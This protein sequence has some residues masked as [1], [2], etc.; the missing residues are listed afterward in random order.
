MAKQEY[1]A[2]KVVED[3]KALQLDG[4]VVSLDLTEDAWEYGAPPPGEAVYTGKL[5]LDKDGILQGLEN[6]K[7]PKTVYFQFN[8]IVKIVEGDYEGV[9]VY[10]R[11]STRIYRGKNISTMAGLIVKLGFKI[12]DKL[13]PKQQA[14][15]M[16]AALKKEPV[17][18]FEI[19]WRG[20]YVYKNPKGD[21]E[22]ENVFRH[23]K[24]FPEDKENPGTRLHV[25]SVT[26]KHNGGMAEVRAQTQIARFY[27]MKEE[28]KAIKAQTV[29]GV[30]KIA[31][32]PEL[33][34][35]S[36][37]TIVK[38]NSGAAAGVIKPVAT[39]EEDINLILA[40]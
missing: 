4:E 7:D 16:Q 30:T 11:V 20:A 2:P 19:D 5:F 10:S 31:E 3:L 1:V 21:D 40:E 36:V 33:E 37:P 14:L 26:N 13:S 12:P 6:E 8:L 25:I 18:K 29:A 15:Y 28:V 38:V 35:A 24:D 9:P 17:I 39:E 23:Y 34:L 32:V 27:G 22:Y